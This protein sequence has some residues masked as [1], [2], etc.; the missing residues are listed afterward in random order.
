MSELIYGN[1][2]LPSDLEKLISEE[3]NIKK[4]IYK[5]GAKQTLNTKI[6]PQLKAE[7]E[8]RDIIRDIQ[9][10]RKE[11]DCRLDQK[12]SVELPAWPH[13]FED[14]IKKQTLT[15]SITLGEKLQ[16]TKLND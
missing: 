12:I 16:I 3:I 6:T 15:N 11:A 5:K 4:I 13:E 9:V 1:Y 10:A 2:Q 7:G 14:E 8:A